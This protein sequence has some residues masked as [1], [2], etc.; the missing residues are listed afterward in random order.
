MEKFKRLTREEMK[1]VKGA[2][3]GTGCL[4]SSVECGFVYNQEY[5]YGWCTGGGTA[6][7]CYCAYGDVEAFSDGCVAP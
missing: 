7:N 1:K 6:P 5:Y 4:G 2:G 3:G